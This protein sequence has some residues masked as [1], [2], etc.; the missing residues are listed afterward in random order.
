[1]LFDLGGASTEVSLV[2]NRRLKETMSLPLGS[3]TLTEK[4]GTQ[5]EVSAK[6]L[7]AMG[8]YIK[9]ILRRLPGI[10][11]TKL[12]LIGI[13]GTVRNLAKIHQRLISYPIPKLHHYT[14]ARTSSPP[15]RF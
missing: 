12:P 3:L 10:E 7:K 6:T 4:F 2:R 9:K 8:S 5:D 11:N 14:I 15:A 1:M 13:G